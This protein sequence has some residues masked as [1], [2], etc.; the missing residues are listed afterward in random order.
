[1]RYRPDEVSAAIL[2]V[3]ERR[4]ASDREVAMQV[5]YSPRHLAHD[6]DTET[7]M[8]VGVPANEVAERAER[9]RAR[10]RRTAGSRCVEPTEHGEA[11]ITAV[12]DP[13]LVR[14]LEVGMVRASR[15]GRAARR[16][17]PRT[18]T[19]TARCSRG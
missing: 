8:G 18:P 11:P 12:H 17:C 2:A 14:F 15:A 9:I 1:M 16:S 3:A 19:R 5:V 7:Y 6:I 4:P 13:G 10:S